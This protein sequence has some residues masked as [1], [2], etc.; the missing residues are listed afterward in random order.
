MLKSQR[1]RKQLS[2]IAFSGAVSG[3]Q[4]S[5]YFTHN[6]TVDLS[7]VNYM[8][9]MDMIG[10]LDDNNPNSQYNRLSSSPVWSD[11]ISDQK[12]FL[13]LSPISIGVS[14]GDHISFIETRFRCCI[15][16]QGIMAILKCPAMMPLRSTTP[17]NCI[18]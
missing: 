10:R 14:P 6:P 12:T 11:I 5:T 15:F 18:S 2:V 4:G 8:V 16:Q 7:T 13:R 1:Q 17:V 9:N 3:W